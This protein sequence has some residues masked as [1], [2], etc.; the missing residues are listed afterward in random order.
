MNLSPEELKEVLTIFRAE[1]VDQI[2][3]LNKGLLE[4]EKNPDNQSNIEEIFRTAHSIKGS[5]R[6]LGL[7][8][9]ELIAH[10]LEDVL[11]LVKNGK[12]A[13]DDQ[14]DLMY[15]SVDKI[16]ETL[17]MLSQTDTPDLSVVDVSDIVN[18][19]RSLQNKE[20]LLEGGSDAPADVAPEPE[21]TPKKAPK[22]AAKKAVDKPAEKV[23]DADAKADE[24][25]EKSFTESDA[26]VPQVQESTQQQHAE[27]EEFIRISISQIDSLMNL[28]GELVTTKIKNDQLVQQ[29][30]DMQTR[31]NLLY[32]SFEDHQGMIQMIDTMYQKATE[33]ISLD[34]FTENE[35]RNILRLVI[36]TGKHIGPIHADVMSVISSSSNE[37]IKTSSLID[38]IQEQVRDTR[39]LPLDT[40]LDLMPR[41]VRDIAKKMNKKVELHI[42]GGDTKL[43]KQILEELKNPLI[44]IIRNSID[45]GIEPPDERMV[46]GKPSMGQVTINARYEGNSVLIEISDDGA[47]INE[48]KVLSK[49]IDKQLITQAQA[50]QLT[51]SEIMN[52]IFAP[53]FSTADIITDISGRGVGMDVVRR[54][55]EKL[56][57]VI[58]IHSESG[59][60]TTFRI[61]LPLTLATI[62]VLIV[63]SHQEKYTIPVISI[64]RLIQ[65]ELDEIETVN[66]RE[67]IRLDDKMI[68]IVH[69]DDLLQ[70]PRRFQYAQNDQTLIDDSAETKRKHP[71]IICSSAEKKVAIIVDRLIDE[72]EVVIKDLGRQFKR[73]PTVMGATILGSGELAMMLDPADLVKSAYSLNIN[74]DSMKSVDIEDTKRRVLVVDDSIT[75]RTLEKNILEQA[76]F[77]VKIAVNGKEAWE[78]LQTDRNFD[79][80]V[81]DVEMP[82]MTGFELVS[83]IKGASKLKHL[84]CILCT[85]LES[86][87]DKRKG[88]ESGANAY[89]TKGSFNQRNL[90]ETIERL[91]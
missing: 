83:H 30:Y 20:D 18:K 88:V 7:E 53:G 90:L 9:I 25:L 41:M 47:G 11:G 80:V 8:P 91:I 29:L 23:T 34:Q 81:S 74:L 89:I 64:E 48:P 38:E 60:G 6:M 3:I 76:G 10:E 62:Q 24:A 68:A 87:K 17:K 51:R 85:S 16:D 52:I 66:K 84:P 61:R 49:A 59:K 75:T 57:G 21:P 50:E 13:V 79:I 43:D 40:L 63:E 39:L 12:L 36:N 70:Q 69:L 42:H 37:F 15:A 26:P 73:V 46:H 27:S 14:I 44:H 58:S 56:K 4:L 32:K 22:K 67:F 19:L 78:L 1:A 55:V 72:Q 5:S 65:V 54:N 82:Y 33:S 28:V 77:D 35:I 71:V 2:T 86:E 45:H 31:V